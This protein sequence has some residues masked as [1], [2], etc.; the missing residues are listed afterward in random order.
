MGHLCQSGRVTLSHVPEKQR[1][2]RIKIM[3]RNMMMS[4]PFAY[5]SSWAFLGR[6]EQ[7]AN[8]PRWLPIKN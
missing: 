1:K 4:M 2:I 5:D 7:D 8:W 3:K 6:M